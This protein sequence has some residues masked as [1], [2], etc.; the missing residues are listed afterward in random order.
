V[1]DISNLAERFRA[2][3]WRTFGSR[4][5]LDFRAHQG[6]ERAIFERRAGTSSSP[7]SFRKGVSFMQQ[8]IPLTRPTC[9]RIR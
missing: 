8:G 7:N 5:P 4:R 1:L 6:I 9:L 3:G 2:F